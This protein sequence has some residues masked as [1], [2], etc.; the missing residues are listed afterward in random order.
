[1]PSADAGAP[2][3]PGSVRVVL[4][5]YRSLENVAARL[6]SA[7]LAGQQVVVVDNG[8]DPDGVRRVCA[9]A[10]AQPVLL[11]VNVGF[12]AGVNAA[13]RALDPSG[14]APILLLNPD[15]AVTPEALRALLAELAAGADGAGPLLTEPTG[16]LQVGPAGGP[17]TLGAVAAY[18]LLLSHLLPRLTGVF[19]TRAQSRR[20]RPVAWV[21]MACL[22][23]R[24]DA[25]VRF[26]P[27]PEDELVYAEDV[28]WG[29]AATAR[30]ADLRLVPEVVVTHEKGAS[31]A[32]TAWVGALERLCRRRLGAVRGGL[33]VACIRAGL[34]LRRAVGRQVT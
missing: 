23:L 30:G 13:V 24:P 25:F 22:L 5:N 26:G 4:V 17:L 28:A 16:R 18:F 12:A 15:V 29:T 8:D 21:C 9:A 31:G 11:P 7:A 33:A 1:M 14:S 10:G 27:V 2:L 6:A 19:L 3:P 34:G 32:S 20:R